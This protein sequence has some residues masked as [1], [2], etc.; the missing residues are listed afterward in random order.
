MLDE[1]DQAM[2]SALRTGQWVD[3]ERLAVLA[4]HRQAAREKRLTAP[5]ALADAAGYYASKGI[6]VFPLRPGEKIPYPGSRGFKDAT[7]NASQVAQWW[8]ERPTSN[9]GVPTGHLFDVIDIDGPPGYRSLADL[10]DEGAVPAILGRAA[11]PR[12]GMHLY[13]APTGG[14]NAASFRPGLDYRGRGGYAV[15]PP[16][17]VGGKRYDWIE[18]FTPDVT[19]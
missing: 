5:D 19:A 7:V 12:G 3:Y 18:P 6:A 16:S 9:I 13:T 11:T 8:A 14:G 4:D 17:I 2:T 10:R 1:L 15:A